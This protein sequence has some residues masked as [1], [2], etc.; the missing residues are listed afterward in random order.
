MSSTQRLTYVLYGYIDIGTQTYQIVWRVSGFKVREK[1]FMPS[2]MKLSL[3]EDNGVLNDF[4][5]TP[6][7]LIAGLPAGFEA[8]EIA[9]IPQEKLWTPFQIGIEIEQSEIIKWSDVFYVSGT[10]IASATVAVIDNEII[11]VIGG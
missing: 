7:S 11:T 2:E 8:K 10:L 4:S 5:G 6:L 9:K 1:G 3:Q